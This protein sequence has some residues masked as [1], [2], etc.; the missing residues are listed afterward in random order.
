MWDEGVE[1]E[2]LWTM[3][4]H[5]TLVFL[6]KGERDQGVMKHKKPAEDQSEEKGRKDIWSF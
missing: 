1:M 5:T 4:I 2:L 6:R 3:N